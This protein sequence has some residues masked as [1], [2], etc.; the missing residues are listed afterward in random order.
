[1]FFLFHLIYFSFVCYNHSTIEA[2][3]SIKY[4][5][6]QISH[7]YFTE[8]TFASILT[9]EELK[10][11]IT[12]PISYYNSS[13]LL[14]TVLILLKRLYHSSF[15]LNIVIFSGALTSGLPKPIEGLVVCPESQL[16][17]FPRFMK[18]AEFFSFLA[19]ALKREM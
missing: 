9:Q 19:N 8:F 16:H 7:Y 17:L 4:S 5:I 12:V 6:L 10:T 15:K 13:F 2:S 18:N 14:D 1:M 3:V 11:N